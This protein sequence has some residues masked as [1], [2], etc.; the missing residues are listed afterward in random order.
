MVCR[1]N[2]NAEADGM[3]DAAEIDAVAETDAEKDADADTKADAG[4]E[5]ISRT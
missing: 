5:T 3:K 2:E 4:T 1:D